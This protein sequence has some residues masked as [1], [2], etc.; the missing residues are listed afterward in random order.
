[1]GTDSTSLR[2]LRENFDAEARGAE[3]LDLVRRLYPI[4]RSITGA[5]NRKTLAILS[6]RLDLHIHEVPSG[7]PVLDWTV[8]PEWNIRE[9]WIKDPQG[10]KI[11]DFAQHNLHVVNYSQPVHRTLPL[12]E[13]APHLHSLPDRP[14]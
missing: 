5:G 6:E 2:S 3:M 8:P 9:A 1:M 14:D 4:C 7:T 11:V 12:A 10:R 13:L